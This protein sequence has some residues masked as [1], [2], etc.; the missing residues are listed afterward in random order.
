[1]GRLVPQ[2]R[3]TVPHKSIIFRFHEMTVDSEDVVDRAMYRNEPLHVG[4]GIESPP[5]PFPF[6]GD[7]VRVL[8]PGV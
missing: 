2:G 1:M 3:I 4:C 8:R 7:L 6:P 5:L